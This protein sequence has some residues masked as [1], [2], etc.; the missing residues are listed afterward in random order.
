[1]RV[2]GGTLR[3]RRLQA[4]A[5]QSLRPT[6]DRVREAL[7][8]ILAPRLPDASFLDLFAGTG[9]VGI[10][11]ASRGCR[12]VVLVEQDPRHARVLQE[13]LQAC[14]VEAAVELLRAPVLPTLRRLDRAGRCF[15]VIFAD[16]P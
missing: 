14:G 8:N 15:P 6:S 16:P 11:A 9:A 1:M 4:P 10:E 5:G 3:G 12:G 13:N 7:F 2:I